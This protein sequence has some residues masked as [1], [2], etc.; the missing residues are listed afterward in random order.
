MWLFYL[1][2]VIGA[3]AGVIY[4]WLNIRPVINA[5]RNLSLLGK[6]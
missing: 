3:I 6:G 2:L 1:L 5:R 4:F